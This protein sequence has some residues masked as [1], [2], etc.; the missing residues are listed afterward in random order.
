MTKFLWPYGT[1]KRWWKRFFLYQERFA[2]NGFTGHMIS[3][4]ILIHFLFNGYPVVR[5]RGDQKYLVVKWIWKQWRRVHL[6]AHERSVITTLINRTRTVCVSSTMPPHY[7]KSSPFSKPMATPS[8]TSTEQ[9]RQ[10]P[11]IKTAWRRQHSIQTIHQDI[12]DCICMLLK[13]RGSHTVQKPTNSMVSCF[14][15][16]K[17][18]QLPTKKLGVYMHTQTHTHYEES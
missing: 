6:Q 2:G 13:K 8:R 16:A 3:K 15:S 17:D 7:K 10:D 9:P 4:G 14:R 11:T 5:K 1:E 18:R 12:T